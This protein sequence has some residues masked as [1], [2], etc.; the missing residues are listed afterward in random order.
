[1]KMQISCNK[2]VLAGLTLA[3]V[4]VLAQ[5]ET[6]TLSGTVLG[7]AGPGGD[8]AGI[9]DCQVTATLEPTGAKRAVATDADGRFVLPFLAPGPYK[10]AVNCTAF[11]QRPERRLTLGVND[12]R[13]LLFT[14]GVSGPI[15]SVD[16]TETGDQLQESASVGTLVDRKFVENLP[17]NGRSF[18][19]LITLTPGVLQTP[20]SSKSPGQFAVNGQRT[21]TNYFTVDGVSANFGVM[22]GP[23]LSAVSDGTLPALSAAGGTNSL[24]SVDAMQEFQVQTSTFAPEFGRSPGGQVSIVTRSGGNAYHGSL[25]NYF[26]NDKLDANDWFANRDGLSRAPVRQNDFGGVFGGPVWVPGV[27]QGKDRTFFFASYE[28]LRL[29]QPQYA[30]DAYPTAATRLR[31]A[32]AAR[33]IVNAYPLPNLGDL[34]GG[35]GRFAASYSNPLNLDSTSVRLDHNFGRATIFGRYSESPSQASSRGPISTY[36]L[37]LNTISL[38]DSKTRTFTLGSTQTWSA[39]ALNETRVNWA[40]HLAGY[41]TEMDSLGGATPIPNSTLFPSFTSPEL[42][43]VGILP[44]GIRGFAAGTLADNRQVQ[45]N[46][47]DNFSFTT[48]AHQIKLGFDFRQLYP[49]LPSPTYQQF[50]VFAGL[51]GPVGMLGGRTAAAIVTA[52]E[53]MRVSLH[54]TSIYAQDTWRPRQR[55]SITYG[56]RWDYNPPPTGLDGKDIY[57]AIGAENPRTARLSPAGFNLFPADRRAF[58]PRLGVSYQVSNRTGWE[59]TVRGGYGIFY[60]LPLGA[61]QSATGNP[62]Y[63]RTGRFAGVPFPLPAAQATPAP[64]T[65]QGRFDQVYAFSD[66]FRLPFTHQ[67]NVAVEQALGG[68][69]ALTVTYVGALGRRLLRRE[70][71]A[72]PRV[73]DTFDSVQITRSAA[74]SD[75]HALQVQFVQRLQKGLQLIASH[76][77]SHSID[78]NSDNINLVL[79][80]S[81]AGVN[82]NRGSSDYDIRHVFTGALTWDIPYRTR[83]TALCPVLK[84]WG[85]DSVFR[86]QSAFPLDVFNRT[87]TLLG[88]YDLRPNLVPGQP[89]YLTG[90]THP[91]GK[92]INRAAFAVP[93]SQQTHGDLGRNVLRAFPL[94]QVDLTVRRQFNITE[95]ANLQFRAEFFNVLNHPV[96]GSPDMNLANRLFGASTQMF[97]RGLGQGGISG[98][99]NPLYSVGAPRSIQLAM[100]LRF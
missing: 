100:K 82:A 85:L 74:T 89:L 51:E 81:L 75:Y 26:R 80:L 52:F 5:S 44:T 1:M 3:V 14:P 43:S 78:S 98:G 47:V 16:I 15:Y 39:R 58:A 68:P 64:V 99:Q 93:A 28:G 23:Q 36:D 9:A 35:F 87:A 2:A 88:S 19:N 4:Q 40:R 24:V 63:R 27:Y 12:R 70:V 79:P 49:D 34:G 76:A 56:I 83:G 65:T 73:Y 53:G 46:V 50:G 48:G 13:N 57:G 22:S 45:W 69:R 62:P 10:V 94:N 66:N 41:R 77:W 91:G 17:L 31:A 61:L 95:T 25:F 6:A 55:L 21:A 54:N 86:A 72:Q 30:T 42:A 60:D 90:D 38:S 96:F 37:S 20:A 84:N 7:P 33:D 97:G 71:F 92:A 18:Q 59:T 11:P 32:P 29:R 67:Y 8:R